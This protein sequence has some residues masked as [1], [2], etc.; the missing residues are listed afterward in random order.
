MA[1]ATTLHSAD[2]G[3]FHHCRKR[4][5]SACQNNTEANVKELQWPDLEKFKQKKKK[6]KIVVTL[7]RNLA[8]TK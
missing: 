5:K 7:W 6:D 8:D 2:T 3:Y 1:R 4:G